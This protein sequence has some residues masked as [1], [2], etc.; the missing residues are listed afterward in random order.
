MNSA[1]VTLRKGFIDI[2]GLQ[3]TQNARHWKG[4]KTDEEGSIQ[5]LYCGE[6]SQHRAIMEGQVLLCNSLGQIKAVLEMTPHFEF[7]ATL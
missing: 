2:K 5:I 3:S 4:F 7:E 6:Y 1:S